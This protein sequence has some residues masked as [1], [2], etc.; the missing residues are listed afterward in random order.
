M[1]DLLRHLEVKELIV[2]EIPRKLSKRIL[3]ESP[4]AVEDEPI[5]SQIASPINQQIKEFFYSRISDTIGSSDALSIMFDPS[6]ESPVEN[7]VTEYFSCNYDKRRIEI[8][9]DIARHLYEIQNAQ[10]SGGLLLFVHCSSQGQTVLAI[11][12]VEKEE[13]VCLEEQIMVDGLRTFNVEHI[14]DL[15]LILY[16]E[17]EDIIQILTR[18]Y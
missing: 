10:N 16:D 11:L 4:D 2:H 15:I 9:Q 8:T 3:R 18:L 6:N 13:W 17:H 14:P 5:L 12:K 1:P 7:L